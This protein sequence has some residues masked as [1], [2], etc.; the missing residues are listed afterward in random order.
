VTRGERRRLILVGLAA[1]VP[2]VL[3]AGW[4]L[5]QQDPASWEVLALMLL[6]T[7]P[8]PLSSVMNVVNLLG[9]LP[10][11][12][13]LVLAISAGMYFWRGA[14]AGTLVAL[15]FASDLAAFAVKVLVGRD[16]PD[17]AIAQHLVGQDSFSFP[18]GHVVRSVALLA[19]LIWLIAPPAWRLRGALMGAVAAA[20]VMGYA[21]MALGVHFPTDVLGGGLLGVAWFALTAALIAPSGARRE[22]SEA[23]R[24]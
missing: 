1:L 21:R 12:A 11:W 19:V 22:T 9:S 17:Y 18:S 10:V 23:T 6:H 4:A 8:G 5:S 15:T 14:A 2:F 16:R 24:A 20:L 7:P 3:L 13:M